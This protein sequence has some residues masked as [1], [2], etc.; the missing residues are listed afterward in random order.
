MCC[1]QPRFK[2]PF[3][4]HAVLPTGRR[5]QQQQQQQLGAVQSVNRVRAHN[6]PLTPHTPRRADAVQGNASFIADQVCAVD[7]VN[8]FIYYVVGSRPIGA[9][10][11]A[12][13]SYSGYFGVIPCYN[14]AYLQ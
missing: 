1:E 5:S 8:G 13:F 4:V 9:C 11:F 7:S 3:D 10:A 12:P 6:V 2:L 14:V